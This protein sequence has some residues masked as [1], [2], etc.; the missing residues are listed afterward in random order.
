MEKQS[1]KL[2]DSYR[3]VFLEKTSHVLSERRRVLYRAIKVVFGIILLRWRIL[4][5]LIE[6][7]ACF[8][9]VSLYLSPRYYIY[10]LYC[11]LF[12]R[13]SIAW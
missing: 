13:I 7:Y 4:V 2:L 9:I 6:V 1:N 5:L 11:I 10:W 3:K 8:T 12:I